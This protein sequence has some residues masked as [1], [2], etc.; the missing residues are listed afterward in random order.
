MSKSAGALVL[1]DVSGHIMAFPISTTRSQ[2]FGQMAPQKQRI[3]WELHVGQTN[4]YFDGCDFH[5]LSPGLFAFFEHQYLIRKMS[6]TIFNI[7]CTLPC[8]LAPSHVVNQS[9][10]SRG[11][12]AHI[13]SPNDVERLIQEQDLNERAADAL[14][15][16][17]AELSISQSILQALWNRFKTYYNSLAHISTKTSISSENP[18]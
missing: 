16:S 12:S 13:A 4:Q 9:R 1:K 8:F 5:I 2:R 10:D 18:S 15:F 11:N 3:C 7:Y 14:R 6:I 17:F